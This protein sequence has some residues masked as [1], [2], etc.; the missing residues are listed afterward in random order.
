[1]NIKN[2][3]H[4]VCLKC[5]LKRKFHEGDEISSTESFR[6]RKTGAGTAENKDLSG[7]DFKCEQCGNDKCKVIDLGIMYGDE[8]WIYLLKC[9]KCNYA[10]RVGEMC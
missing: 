3:K 7:Y 1:M 10:E 4:L 6:R 5:R 2:E 8:D 9:T